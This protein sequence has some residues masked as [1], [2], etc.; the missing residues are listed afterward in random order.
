MAAPQPHR[1]KDPTGTFPLSFMQ[2]LIFGLGFGGMYWAEV[3][4]WVLPL[5]PA[6][7]GKYIDDLPHFSS[8]YIDYGWFNVYPVLTGLG[9]STIWTLL[10]ELRNWHKPLIMK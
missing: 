5:D 8:F 2:I 3:E 9:I 6:T 4:K 7:V 1:Y 10:V